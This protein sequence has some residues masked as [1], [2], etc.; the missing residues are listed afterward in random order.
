MFS[1][2]QTLLSPSTNYSLVTVRGTTTTAYLEVF[3]SFNAT[4]GW[5]SDATLSSTKITI[6]SP[7]ASFNTGTV[8]NFDVSPYDVVFSNNAIA[9]CVSSPNDITL[10]T[11]GLR[12]FRL[13]R[14]G[15]LPVF[16]GTYSTNPV[17]NITVSGAAFNPA[18][19][20]LA[21]S[22]T[23]TSPYIKACAWSNSSGF[24]TFYSNPATAFYAD[25]LGGVGSTTFVK[26]HPSGQAIFVFSTTWPF[27][28]A[29]QWSDVTGFGTKYTAP[30]IP[31]NGVGYFTADAFDVSTNYVAVG[32]KRGILGSTMNMYVLPFNLSTGFGAPLPQKTMPTPVDPL[33]PLKSSD[34]YNLAIHPSEQYIAVGL[35]TF[36]QIISG[37]TP[38]TVRYP[39]IYAYQL[40]SSALGDYSSTLN[41]N[42]PSN[43]TLPLG[44]QW[45][46]DGRVLASVV[47]DYFLEN[48]YINKSTT[49]RYLGSLFF[50][51]ASATAS[52]GVNDLTFPYT[53]GVLCPW[54]PGAAQIDANY[55][56]CN[57]DTA[58]MYT[59]TAS[60]NRSKKYYTP[61]AMRATVSGIFGFNETA[62]RAM[63]FITA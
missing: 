35:D 41:Y 51:F 26:F 38:A 61:N 59:S 1:A 17:T 32:V 47:N 3:S 15:G 20:V 46:P 25:A 22:P 43:S 60:L 57:G 30:S 52:S 9:C 21:Y 10:P 5:N 39:A 49:T 19:T 34:V 55:T 13:G 62:V 8:V 50:P 42:G 29:W 6:A 2:N 45:T 31:N 48:A 11:L 33:Y 53:N 58:A 28:N 54:Y 56:Y 12:V 36:T 27:V 4:S 37:T 40:S 63:K 44:C 18:G 7:D 14:S 16:T 23:R 24:G